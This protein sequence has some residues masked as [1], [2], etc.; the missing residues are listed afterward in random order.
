MPSP[1]ASSLLRLRARPLMLTDRIY[2]HIK[3]PPLV[4][5]V[6]DT[7][8][9][10]RLRSLHQLGS[11]SFVYP[12]ASHTRFEHS[13][14]VSY[15]AEGMLTYL[16]SEQPE[17][18]LTE[19]KDVLPCMLAGLLHDVGHGPFSHL[20]ED[21]IAQRCGIEGGFNHEDMSDRLARRA[22]R[23]L[24][25]EAQIQR[26]VELMHG[27][28]PPSV[29]YRDLI[30]SS[31][32]GTGIDIDRVDYLHRDCVMCFGRAA[33]DT[34]VNRLLFNSRL[35][36]EEV[37]GG[38]PTWRQIFE[39]KMASPLLEL[40]GLRAKLHRAVYQH[41]VTKAVGAM[42]GDAIG[43]AAPHY[44][45]DGVHTLLDCVKDEELFLKLGDW[46]LNAIEAYQGP[47]GQLNP[48]MRAAHQLLKR[49]RNRDLYRR[50]FAKGLHPQCKRHPT[51]GWDQVNWSERILAEIPHA[52]GSTS[53][54][55]RPIT[56][57]DFIVDIIHVH[58]GKGHRNPVENILFFNPKK[59]SEKPMRLMEASA[60]EALTPKEEWEA[61]A[62]NKPLRY[63]EEF[64]LMVYEKRDT[65]GM[66][67]K[68]C[69]ALAR[70]PDISQLF[71]S[72]EIPFCN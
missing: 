34:R 22:L 45:I 44:K 69:E 64:T 50:V 23:G 33:I 7:P 27:A 10:Q 66:L 25:D 35:W 42:I 46:V 26:V 15:M 3:V 9:V 47:C 37:E 5:C 63:F 57:D 49:L 19:E 12:G 52:A 17:L 67:A 14:G 4:A 13:I 20:F 38:E 16:R 28:A 65:N 40:F 56:R 30:A 72:N 59:P 71:V 32:G 70:D 60:R 68:A 11:S 62:Q 6:L 21:V 2:D 58:Y 61:A 51:K 18:E 31:P 41:P 39:K 29:P 53:S 8:E 55:T 54:T 24:L 48:D 36:L 1:S 43:L